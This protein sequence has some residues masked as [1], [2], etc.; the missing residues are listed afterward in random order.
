MVEHGCAPTVV[1]VRTRPE[2]LPNSLLHQHIQGDWQLL[3]VWCTKPIKPA[4]CLDQIA[5]SIVITFSSLVYFWGVGK[6]DCSLL[7]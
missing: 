5:K 7:L 3:L 6:G 1:S 4:A 2:Q